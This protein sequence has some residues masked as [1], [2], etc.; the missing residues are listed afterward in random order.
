MPVEIG[1]DL[2]GRCL[3]ISL[4]LRS[5]SNTVRLGTGS[6]TPDKAL[7]LGGADAIG[8]ALVAAEEAAD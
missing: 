4:L 3:Q 2:L 1:E 6:V 8:A 7:G 5:D